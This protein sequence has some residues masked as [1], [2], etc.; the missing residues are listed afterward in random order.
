MRKLP[1]ERVQAHFNRDE[2][3]FDELIQ[4]VKREGVTLK[5]APR[6]SINLVVCLFLLSLHRNELG[7]D[8]YGET[9]QILTDLVAGY[10]TEGAA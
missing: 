9:M 8:V 3:F 10:I 4:K 5:A 2:K 6:V 7:E 1:A